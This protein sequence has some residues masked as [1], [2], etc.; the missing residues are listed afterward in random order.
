ME[1]PKTPDMRIKREGEQ[2]PSSERP[3]KDK[4]TKGLKETIDL[5]EDFY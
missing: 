3:S 4:R 1:S 5:T 2:G